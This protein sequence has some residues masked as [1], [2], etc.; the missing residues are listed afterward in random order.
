M[1]DHTFP[2]LYTFWLQSS[3]KPHFLP[4]YAI[5]IYICFLFLESQNMPKKKKKVNNEGG[6]KLNESE[7]YTDFLCPICLELLIE[8]ITLPCNHEL[9]SACFEPHI[10]SAS[11]CCPMCRKRLSIWVRENRKKNTLIN[12]TR[13]ELIQK[14]FPEQVKCRLEGLETFDTRYEE[15]SA[16]TRVLAESG[17]LHKEYQSE[18]EKLQEEDAKELQ[19]NLD[20]IQQL[21]N[22]EHEN[23][24]AQEEIDRLAAHALQKEE[25]NNLGVTLASPT[26]HQKKLL[27]MVKPR[28]LR[29]SPKEVKEKPNIKRKSVSS[30][31]D[32]SS[33][34]KRS[35]SNYFKSPPQVKQNTKENLTPS[36]SPK[37][38]SSKTIH[39]IES[40]LELARK[41][42]YEYYSD[43]SIEILSSPPAPRKAFSL[44]NTTHQT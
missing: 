4:I 29:S 12:Q 16:P 42:Q 2:A 22:E 9:C 33:H 6:V 32:S 20:Y 35:I 11:L 23:M 10:K 5:A 28:Q 27:E 31:T 38:C 39:A 21:E 8:P 26:E 7:S 14:L 13:W 30:K 3:G 17:E 40:D 37:P 25:M 19:L 44:S 36:S 15:Y 41:L 34:K 24:K 18:I 1:S 43:D